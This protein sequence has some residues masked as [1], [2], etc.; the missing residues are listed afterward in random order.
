MI[1][2]NVLMNDLNGVLVLFGMFRDL[3]WWLCE[4]VVDVFVVFE[5]FFCECM[6]VGEFVELWVW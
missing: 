3:L 6:V 1:V 5:W 2:L 4:D